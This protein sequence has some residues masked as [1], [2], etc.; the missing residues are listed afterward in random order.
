MLREVTVSNDPCVQLLN[1][2][3]QKSSSSLHN[4]PILQ[5]QCSCI[6]NRFG[7]FSLKNKSIK[8]KEKN[9][10]KQS[11][12]SDFTLQQAVRTELSVNVV[13]DGGFQFKRGI[14]GI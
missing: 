14:S 6:S 13:V 10:K 1:T 3:T 9:R 5:I 4:F 7:F 8:K 2:H 11:E 12:M